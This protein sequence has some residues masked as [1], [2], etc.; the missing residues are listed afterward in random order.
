MVRALRGARS[1]LVLCQG[2]VIRSVFAAQVLAARL[3]GVRR[4]TVR[5]AGLTTEPGWRAHPRVIARCGALGLDVSGHSSVP[6]TGR[7]VEGADVV[8][9]M[10][11]AQLVAVRRQFRG[12]AAK[13]FL[14]TSLAPAVPMEVPDPAGKD[15]P[16][17]DACL[18]H[19]ASALQPL[20]ATMVDQPV[21]GVEVSVTAGGEAG[22]RS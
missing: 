13:T 21:A 3:S 12:A 15:D 22:W 14:L 6:V 8:L 7:M 20:I 17:V 1:V 19:I 5:S 9:V 16:V 2:N 4:I 18:D 11:V 10:E